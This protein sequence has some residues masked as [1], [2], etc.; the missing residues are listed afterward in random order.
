MT[1]REGNLRPYRRPDEDLSVEDL[2]GGRI[3]S[4]SGDGELLFA[5]VTTSGSWRALLACGDATVA[6][7][8]G[9]KARAHHVGNR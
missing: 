6:N 5:P 9:R 3:V 7:G 2:A 8:L 4:M 1:I